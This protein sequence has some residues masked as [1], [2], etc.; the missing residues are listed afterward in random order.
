M[1]NF[2]TINVADAPAAPAATNPLIDA[3]GALAPDEVLMITPDEG[4]SL[5]G[6]KTGIGRTLNNAGFDKTSYEQWDVDNVVYLR[7]V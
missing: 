6:T 3:F 4:K 2:E 5:R 7:R 1:A